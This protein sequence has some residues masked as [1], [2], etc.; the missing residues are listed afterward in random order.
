M[1]HAELHRGKHMVPGEE[2]KHK[3]NFSPSRLKVLVLLS[4]LAVVMCEKEELCEVTHLSFNRNVWNMTF[5]I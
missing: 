1:L 3:E 4:R 5:L 2:Y